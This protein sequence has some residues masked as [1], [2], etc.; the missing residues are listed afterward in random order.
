MTQAPWGFSAKNLKQFIVNKWS[1][2]F[3][4]KYLKISDDILSLKID[5]ILLYILLHKLD[6]AHQLTYLR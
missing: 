3:A 5:L 6:L 2:I 1:P 4:T